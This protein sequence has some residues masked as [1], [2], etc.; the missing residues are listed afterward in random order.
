MA[1]F[2][3]YAHDYDAAL[4]RGLAVSGE[5]KEYFAQG[6]VEWLSRC[7]GHLGFTARSV[8]DYGCGTGT[9]E[10]FLIRGLRAESVLGLDLSA[11]SLDVA[12]E[13]HSGLPVRYATTSEHVPDASIDLAYCNGVFHHVPPAE[14]LAIAGYIADCLRP[15]G[16]FALWD[17]NPWNP[18]A[19]LVMKRIPFDRD[20]VML[21][22]RE[23][24]ELVRGAGLEVV[25]TDHCFVFPRA[26]RALRGIER[27]VAGL[28]LGAQFQVLARKREHPP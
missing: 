5:G 21:S 23:A 14:R 18:G 9:A 11:K 26:L 22:A 3:S 16:L 10:P 1:G 2:D 24:R 6:R 28:P 7:L 19:R 27:H 8:V 25:R 12:R 15:G 4:N 17:N 13:T 20:A